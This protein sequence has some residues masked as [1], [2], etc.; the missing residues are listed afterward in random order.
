MKEA[1]K[2]FSEL[3]ENKYNIIF[4]YLKYLKDNNILDYESQNDNLLILFCQLFYDKRD[5]IIFF[6]TKRSR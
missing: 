6:K 5:A 2:C 1:E 4:K 3:K